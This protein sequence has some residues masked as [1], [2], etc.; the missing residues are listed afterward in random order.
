MSDERKGFKKNN[1]TIKK[2]A[3]VIGSLL[4]GICTVTTIIVNMGQISTLHHKTDD[5][6]V[7]ISENDEAN[8]AE[9]N[10]NKRS[11]K[12]SSDIKEENPILDEESETAVADSSNNVETYSESTDLF[13][14]EVD[15]ETGLGSTDEDSLS[16]DRDSLI[17]SVNDG[18]LDYLKD[19]LP[20]YRV[21]AFDN[22]NHQNPLGDDTVNLLYDGRY[23]T[24]W[25]VPISSIIGQPVISYHA[26][27]RDSS[28]TYYDITGI[29]IVPGNN[30]DE[31]SFNQMGRPTEMVVHDSIHDI[32]LDLSDYSYSDNKSEKSIEFLF[33]MPFRINIAD[34]ILITITGFE[35]GDDSEEL[36]ISELYFCGTPREKY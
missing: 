31:E 22:G 29:V 20:A 13:S 4:A 26:A 2:V 35:S 28:H 16:G 36:C 1:S 21:E 3:T 34:S 33:D 27:A 18:K 32:T 6:T 11:T 10:N 8:K 30:T 17:N 23:D 12:S 15:D 9:I 19:A 25:S 24:F 14:T 5:S 7:I